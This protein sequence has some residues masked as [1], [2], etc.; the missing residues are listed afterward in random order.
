MNLVQG[1]RPVQDHVPGEVPGG[2]GVEDE[3]LFTTV[4]YLVSLHEM[5]IGLGHFNIISD[6]EPMCGS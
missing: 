6:P 1:C 2:G 4:R 5:I 3:E